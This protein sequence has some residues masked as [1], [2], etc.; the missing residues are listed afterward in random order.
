MR[1]WISSETHGHVILLDILNHPRH[2]LEPTTMIFWPMIPMED[3]GGPLRQPRTDRLP[4]LRQAVHQAVPGHCG[5]HP[6][7]QECIKRRQE[8]ADGSAR[9]RW[10]TI[11]LDGGAPGT[12]CAASREGTHC[13]SGFGIPRDA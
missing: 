7:H 1:G 9:C 4:P 6:I 5:G 8:E 12:T 2:A 11:V 13:D 10:L 3:Q